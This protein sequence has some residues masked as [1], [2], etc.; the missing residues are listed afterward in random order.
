M[1]LGER[2]AGAFASN[3][4]GYAVSLG[5][6]LLS[7]PLLLGAWGAG[8]YGEWLLVT[9][10]PAYLAITDAGLGSAASNAMAMHAARDERRAAAAVFQ[11]VGLA[12]LA[13][14]PLLF[15]PLGLL[16]SL[17]P[18][19]SAFGLTVITGPALSA[20][21]ALMLAQVWLAQHIQMLHAGFRC[22]GQYA[23]STLLVHLLRIAEF[24]AL[25]AAVLAGGGPIAGALAMAAAKGLGVLVMAG[26]LYARAPW[27]L[28]PRQ[29]RFAEVKPLLRPG[30]SF[31][32]F[33]LVGALNL[34]APLLIVGALFGPAAVAAFS[35]ARMMVRAVQQLLS[36][37][38]LTVWQET[39]H[40]FGAGDRETL[41][42]IY[43]LA[44]AA[45]LWLG[46]TGAVA[47]AVL[48][49]AAY[50]VWTQT[51]V[52][53]DGLT[54]AL[55]LLA[56]A[57]NAAWY[58]ASVVFSATNRPGGLAAVS[59]I[60]NIAVLAAAWLLAQG[61]GL[62]GVAL[63]LLFGEILVA[64]YVLPASL[65][66]VGDSWRGLARAALSPLAMARPFR[67][68]SQS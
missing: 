67:A 51:L 34:Q 37:V 42:R 56:L 39:S 63:A 20:M 16:L 28:S 26:L 23:R 33:P 35:T 45:S 54:F 4:F 1:S 36:V 55:L 44:A 49:P 47:L 64:L 18:I 19:A 27:L 58:G 68:G 50:R 3:V 13:I 66:F 22:A 9:T 6:Q 46:L 59:L 57:V 2:L 14:G 60:V 11:S 17:S 31:V 61:I 43:R 7:V 52:A 21:I 38:G 8:A 5:V 65:R 25:A 30:L 41:R 40:A 10:I 48:G 29:L 15:L 32:V 24:A 62:P 12:V 53:F